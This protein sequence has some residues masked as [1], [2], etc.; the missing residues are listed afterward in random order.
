MICEHA[1]SRCG[2]LVSKDALLAAEQSDGLC[3]Q[4][5]QWLA[6]QGVANT[7]SDEGFDLYAESGW[8]PLYPQGG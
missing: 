1:D 2:T 5:S 8:C 4:V 7:T 3:R 6:Q